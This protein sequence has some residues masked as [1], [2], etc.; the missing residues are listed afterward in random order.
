MLNEAL[1]ICIKLNQWE[2]AVQLSKTHNLRDVDPLLSRY[3]E[4]LTGSNEKT[5]AAV[6]LYRRAGKYLQ[7]ART[8]FD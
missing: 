2:Y 1:D 7:A 3:A 8:V 5:L 6:Q 4:E